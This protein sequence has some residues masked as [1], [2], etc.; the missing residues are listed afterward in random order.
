M[1]Q[2]SG[3]SS[4]VAAAVYGYNGASELTDLKYN[5]LA[6]GT[7]TVLAGYHWDYNAAGA[8]SDMYSHNDSNATTPNTT[9]TGTGS[10]WG[11]A[12]YSYDPTA[13]AARARATRPTSPTHRP[14]TPPSPTIPTAIA[15]ASRGVAHC[16]NDRRRTI[17]CFSTARYYYTYDAEGNRTAK[18]QISS[19][20]DKSL[21]TQS[22]PNTDAENITIYTWDNANQ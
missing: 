1:Y 5:S 10:N 9:F 17:G 7:G 20:S 13:Q 14:P 19:G 11:K 4:L 6:D 22:S 21:G 16:D 3:T 15:R 2:S 8:V 12:T 18:Y